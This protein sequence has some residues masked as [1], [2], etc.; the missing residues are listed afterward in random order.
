MALLQ[1]R[2]ELG[3]LVACAQA[4][5]E[6]DDGVPR[7][8]DHARHQ[9]CEAHL[10]V[11]L[12]Q[13]FDDG[14]QPVVLVARCVLVEHALEVRRLGDVWRELFERERWWRHVAVLGVGRG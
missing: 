8:G 1:V 14:T 7:A 5:V 10:A 6:V 13:L 3:Q 11:A 2:D 4:E 12:R 9:R